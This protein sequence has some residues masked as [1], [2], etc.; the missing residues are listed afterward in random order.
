MP[1]TKKGLKVETVSIPL[2]KEELHEVGCQTEVWTEEHMIK[3]RKM[4]RKL[5]EM[6]AVSFVSPFHFPYMF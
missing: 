2:K 1:K 3:Y 5:V 6:I 4:K